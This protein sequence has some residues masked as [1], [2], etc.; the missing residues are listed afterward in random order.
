MNGSVM[1]LDGAR[2]VLTAML[3]SA[4]APNCTASPD[5]ASSLNSS[6]SSSSLTNTRTTIARKTTPITMHAISPNS[7][8]MTEKT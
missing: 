6:C 4:C 2:P 1:P 5:A 7:S 8:P 3:T